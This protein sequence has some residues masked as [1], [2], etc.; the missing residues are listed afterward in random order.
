[1]FSRIRFSIGGVADHDLVRGHA[2]A[3]VLELAQRLRDH[4]PR[5]DSDSIGAHHLLFR[6]RE[7]V[8]DAVDGLGGGAGVQGAEDQVPGLGGGQRQADGLQV[9]QLAH[10]DHVRVF[11][12]GGA[13]R[14]GEAQRV[15]APPRA[16]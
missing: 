8:D 4:A 13:Q 9:A 15:R 11:A 7:D 3:A 5:S 6:R 16:G 12:Q 2:A 10:Q 14:V 1:L